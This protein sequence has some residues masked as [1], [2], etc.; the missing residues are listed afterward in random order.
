MKMENKEL[1]QLT[2]RLM[3]GTAESPSSSLNMRIMAL[4]RRQKK[5]DVAFVPSMP[6]LANYLGWFLAYI[7][8]AA[9]AFY[10]VY[11]NKLDMSTI[12]E[13]LTPYLSL[14]LTASLVIP[15]YIAGVWWDKR[16]NKKQDSRKKLPN[17][18]IRQVINSSGKLSTMQRLFQ[19]KRM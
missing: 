10:Y 15:L 14:I 8:L 7:A 9:G 16:Q 13:E 3:A 12:W 17:K 1:D 19:N 18:H 6:S 2:R 11:S 5:P 4:I